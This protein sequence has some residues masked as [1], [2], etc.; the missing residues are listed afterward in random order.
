VE[1]PRTDLPYAVFDEPMEVEHYE[2]RDGSNRYSSLVEGA[3]HLTV[4]DAE[5]LAVRKRADMVAASLQDAPLVFTDGE[6][7]YLR[8]SERRF[9]TATVPPAGGGAT[10]Y[11][12][13]VEFT[14]MIE[15]F[16]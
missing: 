16:F 4:Y 6:L 10:L 3:F 5:K 8:R 13:I 15:R 2:S 12:R 14:Y 11:K 1:L 9:P 7:L